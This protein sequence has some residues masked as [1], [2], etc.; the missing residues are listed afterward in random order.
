M[1]LMLPF[2]RA[3]LFPE[4][5]FEGRDM[6][7]HVCQLEERKLSDLRQGSLVV[8]QG[9]ILSETKTQYL[10]PTTFQYIPVSVKKQK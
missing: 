8:G 9:I 7:H 10:I 4:T 3:V 2:A 6:E 5:M 1:A